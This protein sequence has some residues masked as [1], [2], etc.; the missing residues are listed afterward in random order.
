MKKTNFL[1]MVFTVLMCGFFS[2]NYAGTIYLSATGNDTNDGLTVGNAVKSFT[3]AQ[4]VAAD[5]DIIMVS[6]MI[7]FNLEPGI[8]LPLGVAI[9][10]SLTIQGTSNATDGFDGSGA[11]RFLV[12]GNFNVTLKNMKLINGYSDVNNGGALTVNTATNSLS[13]ENVIFDTNKNASG[14]AKTGAAVHVDNVNGATFKNCVFSNNESSKSGAVYIT[15]WAANS[16]IKFEACAFLG[17][18]ANDSFGGSALYIRANTSAN[19]TLNMINC[20]VKGNAVN[21]PTNGGAIYFGAKSPATTKVN[22][23]N[24]TITENTTA[25]APTNGAGIYFLNSSVGGCW[26]NL[27]ISNCLIEGNTAG[28]IPS[29]LGVNTASPASPGGGSSTVPGYILVQNSIIG[30]V[31]TSVLNVPEATNISNSTYNYLTPTS[32]SADWIAKLDTF[33]ATTNSYALLAGSPAIGFASKALLTAVSVTTDQLGKTRPSGFC[34]AGSVEKNPVLGLK[35]NI[36]N[37]FLVYRNANNQITVENSKTDYSGSI[38]LYNTLGQ[39]MLKT[40]VKGAISTI[41]KSLNSGVYIVML[42]NAEGSYSKK[43]IIN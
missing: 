34:S 39:V 17:N 10:K 22:I 20:T 23:I 6:G 29:D 36:E 18:M 31:P 26:G 35:K 5:G 33:N 2:M 7:D 30:G 38:T 41:D 1:K 37:S 40:P 21:T 11:T 3:Q 15:A 12:I 16:T 43:V 19:T 42:N 24:C 13:C 28:G 27:Y 4:T 32:T 9:T 14:S 8:S 25:G